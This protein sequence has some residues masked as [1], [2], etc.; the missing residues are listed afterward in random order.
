MFD[1]FL[2]CSILSHDLMLMPSPET[3]DDPFEVRATMYRL[4]LS[5]GG[6]TLNWW[7]G[8]Y[9][10]LPICLSLLPLAPYR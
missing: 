10:S 3:T 8:S 7:Y 6:C 1:Y 5:S 4:L 9:G 2:R